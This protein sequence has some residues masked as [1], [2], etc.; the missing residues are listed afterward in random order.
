M[1]AA[2][3]GLV[4]KAIDA[5][6]GV[7]KTILQLKNLL[8]SVLAK[9]A[10]VIGEI[11]ADPIGFLGHLV[12]G[13]KAGLTRFV[14]NIGAHLQEGLMGWLFGALGGAGIEI[15]KTFDLSGI[16]D[17][18]LQV[19]GLTYRAIRARVVKII[20]EPLMARMEQTVDVFKTLATE[21][22][23]GLWR[24]IKDKVGDF[25]DLVLGSIKT[26]LIEKVIKAG[27]FWLIAFLNPAAAFVKAVKAIIDI[28]QFLMERGSE[29]M[30]FVSSIVD[31]LGSIAKGALGIVAEKVEGSLAK[32][33]PLAISFLASLLGLGG[34]SEKIHEVIDKVRAPINKA[35]D[36]V[37]MGAVKGFKKLFG[38]ATKWVK[39][40]FQQGKDWAKGKVQ[41]VK[42]RLTGADKKKDEEPAATTAE[43]PK[44]EDTRTPEQKQTDV[45]AAV[46]EV[47]AAREKTDGSEESAAKAKMAEVKTK[48]RLKDI[49]LVPDAEGKHHVEAEINPRARGATF[50]FGAPKETAW[51]PLTADECGTWM[52]TYISPDD[53]KLHGTPPGAG[54]WPSWWPANKPSS[55]DWWVRGHLLNENLGGPGEKK[56]LTPITKRCNNQHKLV[57]ESLVKNA[58]KTHKLLAY[59][60][61]AQYGGG[62]SLTEDPVKNPKKGVWPKLTTGLD[63]TWEFFDENGKMTG[64]GKTTIPNG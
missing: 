14:G 43:E 57:V 26:F 10:D 49:Q 29:I 42:D 40:K 52:L 27:I 31:S 51:G 37:V 11:L 56:N 60:V 22:I 45:N 54:T 50:G 61:D 13:V 33:L 39:G 47:E 32:A 2:N 35:I 30:S 5:I 36:F 53:D 20:G 64:N 41:D 46:Q 16:V 18:V 44:G 12:D 23:A 59:Y 48:Y 17:L 55:P 28:V 1:K 19:L 4:D 7:I 6:G 62:P 24:F 15:P 25:E 63:C 34:I 9:A 38:G 8:L 3:K 21:G 58:M